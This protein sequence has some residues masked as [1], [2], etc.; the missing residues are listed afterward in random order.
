M[1]KNKNS[2]VK[3]VLTQLISDIFEKN[4]NVALNHK[5]VAA[6]LNLTDL[7]STDTILEILV[8]QTE[9]GL[10][11]RPERGKFR[12]KDLKTFVTGTVDMT[13]D[14]SAFI[15][16]DDEFEKDIFVAPRKLRNALHGD[17][18]KVYVFGKKTSGRK[19]E[20]EVVESSPGQKPILSEWPKF[21]NALPLSFQTTVKCCTI[22]L[23]H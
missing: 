5:Q 4:R 2:Q 11:I 15:V 23:C 12:L 18:V 16:P 8:E 10:F 9:K 21:P 3:L 14:G 13:A 22:F 17:K 20:G 19:N 6:K 7:A 1:A